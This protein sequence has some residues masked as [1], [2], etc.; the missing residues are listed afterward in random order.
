MRAALAGLLLT[1]CW[2]RIPG[3]WSDY[4]D[5]AFPDDASLV[6]EITW[7][8]LRGGYWTDGDDGDL[9]SGA[10]WWG[11]SPSVGSRAIDQFVEGPG[12][13]QNWAGADWLDGMLNP[14]GPNQSTVSGSQ[15]SWEL[16]W[17]RSPDLY[18]LDLGG[19]LAPSIDADY[20]IEPLV[21]RFGPL[22][23]IDVYGPPR[24]LL[25]DP[26]LDGEDPPTLSDSQLHF[27]WEP[28]AESDVVVV[29]ETVNGDFDTVEIVSCLAPGDST[30]FTVPPGEF[31]LWSQSYGAFVDIGVFR[32]AGGDIGGH[33]VNRVAGSYWQRGF[34]LAGTP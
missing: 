34:I 7:T 32:E 17:Q 3:S 5:G 1:A 23:P 10:V 8:E 30:G 11:V 25:G 15:V 16:Q 20:Q 4:A 27:D 2:P 24:L 28:V 14:N 26:S 9:V 22:G 31:T 29:I 18:L 33:G 13:S 6:G 12:C 19:Q 21:T